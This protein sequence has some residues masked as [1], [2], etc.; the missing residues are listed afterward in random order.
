MRQSSNVRSSCSSFD[1]ASSARPLPF[2]CVVV[3]VRTFVVWLVVS[4][5]VST[6]A[7]VSAQRE[8]RSSA[9]DVPSRVP[10]QPTYH[11]HIGPILYANCT[12]CHRPGEI[13]PFS[14]LT[15]EDARKRAKTIERVTRSRYMPPWLPEE[16]WGEFHGERRLSDHEIETISRWVAA[17]LPEGPRAAARGLP[18]FTQGWQLGEP[19]LVVEMPVGYSVPAAGPDIYRNFVLPLDLAEDVWVQAIEVRPS[20]RAVLHHTLIFEDATGDAARLEKQDRSGQPGF[21]RMD[22]R[23]SSQIGAWAVGGSARRLPGGLA[24]P[25][26]RGASIVLSSHFH[27]S[28]KQETEKTRIGLFFA[29]EAPERT[30]LDFQVPPRYGALWGIDIPAGVADYVVTDRF[31][32]PCDIELVGAWGHAHY[33]CTSMRAIAKLPDGT[34]TKLFSIREWDFDWQNAYFY[35]NAVKLPKGS[36]IESTLHYDNSAGNPSNPSDPPRRVRWGLQSTDEMGS[37][38]FSC[39]AA[40]EGDIAVFREGEREQ[41]RI[42]VAGAARRRVVNR[43]DSNHDGIVTRD[44]VPARL[45]A[46]VARFDVNADGTLQDDELDAIVRATQRMRP[47]GGRA[48]GDGTGDGNGRRR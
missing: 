4:A 3:R 25:L 32:V 19:D 9:H 38:I 24:R 43:Y 37:L 12:E 18:H 1:A 33:L 22:F 31:V 46:M 17:G 47:R 40:K 45:W 21:R 20:A 48:R 34:T 15:Y 10:D 11:E 6:A 7:T 5:M 39:V 28:G 29:K 42:S 36:I 30:L 27:P 23:G 2:G 41:A 26:R 14:L 13:A 44:E 16:G 8:S 35:R